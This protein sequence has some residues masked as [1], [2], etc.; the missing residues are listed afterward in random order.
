MIAHSAP[1]YWPAGLDSIL[2]TIADDP[3]VLV[4]HSNAGLLVPM[5][6]EALGDQVRGVVFV[7]AAIPGG[8]H[9]STAAFID[10]LAVVD[11]LLPPWTSWWDE[12]DV[13]ALLPD[14]NVRAEVEA[15]QPRM[16]RAYYDH[17]PPVP[18]GWA[19]PPCGYL[20]FGA[21][22]DKQAQQAADYGWPTVYLPGGHLH[23]LVDPAAVAAAVL[24]LAGAWS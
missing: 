15:E 12:A 13:A 19:A 18:D 22:Y 6:T 5:I 14:P 9:H 23:M 3:V 16:P 8:G 20:W 17:L 10:R 2:Q 4:P 7:D 1:P 24:E 11:G 21:P